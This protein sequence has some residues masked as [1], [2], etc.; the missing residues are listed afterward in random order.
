MLISLAVLFFIGV[1]ASA[2]E[3]LI[4]E[5]PL[6]R[7]IVFPVIGEVT[8][9]DD[10]GEPRSG[11]RSHEGVD[12]LGE[13]MQ[14]LIAAVSGVLQYVPYPQPAWG[15]MISIKDADG[16]EYNY[17]HI[18]NDTPGTDDGLADGRF[19]YAPGIV[20][21]ERVRKGQLVGWMGDSGN[22]EGSSP[23]LH[24]E[25]RSPDGV[26]L[27]PYTSLLQAPHRAKPAVARRT[28]NE[29]LPYGTFRGGASIAVGNLEIDPEEEIITGA[30]AGYMPRV[31]WFDQR[32][33]ALQMPA[34]ISFLAF[35]ETF[36]GG[37][38]VASGDIDGDGIDEIIVGA[39]VGGKSRVRIF[40]AGGTLLFGFRAYRSSFVGGVRVATADMTGDGIDEIITGTGSGMPAR[41]RIWNAEGEKISEFDAFGPEMRSGVDVSASDTHVGDGDMTTSA[42]IVVAAGSGSKPRVRVYTPDGV[43]Q[44]GFPVFGKKFR[45]GVRV[46]VRD[47]MI[48]ASPATDGA[49]RFRSFDLTGASINTNTAFEP[50]WVGGYDVALSRETAW[51]IS[52]GGRNVSVRQLE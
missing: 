13:K 46:D 4:A 15:F 1:P 44:A 19:A 8:F 22:A 27:S 21:G 20:Q 49:P 35:D 34:T 48:L 28:S 24:F 11:R 45:G 23:H 25:M 52:S 51:V 50:W 41:V 33:G 40:T 9:T 43:L 10:F 12:M 5:V 3:T 17:V 14:P 38:D 26:A 16:Y 18:N 2:Q 7:E 37:V 31:K 47:G 30:G 42:Q 32:G 39:G 29:L 36:L 6:Q